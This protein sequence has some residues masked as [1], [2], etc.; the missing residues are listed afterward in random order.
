MEEYEPLTGGAARRAVTG[1]EF[2]HRFPRLHPFLLAELTA[3]TALLEGPTGEVHPSLYPILALLSRLRPSAATRDGDNRNLAPAAFVPLVRRCARGRPLAIRAAA[4]RALAPLVAPDKV[5]SAVTS[6]LGNLVARFG[7]PGGGGGSGRGGSRGGGDSNSSGARGKGDGAPRVGY[8]AAHGALL[9][10]KAL[11]GPGGPAAA[12]DPTSR[13]AAVDATAG[14]L[15]ACAWIATESPVA[16]AAAEWLACAEA[17][18]ALTAM[19]GGA[20]GRVG[21]P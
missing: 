6:T 1:D 13:A 5:P 7:T 8:N 10:V 18:L 20:D 12:A 3:A 17:A 4:A 14:A 2:F 19:D 11:L 9:C 15:A 16:A 21:L